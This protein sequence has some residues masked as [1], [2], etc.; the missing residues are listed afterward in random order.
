LKGVLAYN[1]DHQGWMI[2]QAWELSADQ[3]PAWDGDGVLMCTDVAALKG[4]VEQMRIPVV[5][6]SA[7]R[8]IPS[9]PWVESD[10]AAIGKM[11]AEHLLERGLRHFGFC[12]VEGANFSDWRRD[13]FVLRLRQAGFD[14]SV[15]TATDPSHAAQ[16]EAISR[17]LA[18]LPKP[19]G[20]MGD[21]PNRGQEVLAA[22][23]RQR[24]A[25]P[26]D[27]AIIT[28]KIG[29]EFVQLENPP[30]SSVTLNMH[31]I[32]YGA[33]ALL[34]RLMSGVKEPPGTAHLVAPLEVVTR[35]STDLLDIP[36]PQIA[37]ALRYI[38]Q[39]AC[40][41]I[42][43]KDVLPIASQ[44]RRLLDLRFQELVGRTPHEEIVRVRMNRV[45]ELLTG[46]DLS[47]E[48]IAARTGF[49]KG[50]HLSVKF[51][52]ETGLT[53]GKYRDQQTAKS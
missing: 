49:A 39:H 12:G 41:G 16:T 47:L 15:Y 25:V 46:T 21:P 26:E 13:A 4:M 35:Q 52:K 38:R 32:G 44:S 23:H 51:R 40:E 1:Q 43:V 24:L 14:C 19:V 7:G 3:W 37:A 17:W 20:V 31:R 2:H 8:V 27:V 30:L 5:D 22:S 33:A 53:P 28:V 11:A 18:A 36:D 42:Q 6:I 48:A 45:K 10:N 34:D 29:N 9:L 50:V